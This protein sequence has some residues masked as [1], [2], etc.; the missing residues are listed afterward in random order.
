MTGNRSCLL[1]PDERV[2][3]LPGICYDGEKGRVL[4]LTSATAIV[5]TFREK[6]SAY[7]INAQVSRTCSHTICRRIQHCVKARMGICKWLYRSIHAHNYEYTYV[8]SVPMIVYI[9][10]RTFC[11]LALTKAIYLA[12][13]YIGIVR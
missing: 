12:H 2:S 1:R 3:V 7:A 9:H 4:L 13:A 5:D 10:M 11:Y 6:D 8:Y